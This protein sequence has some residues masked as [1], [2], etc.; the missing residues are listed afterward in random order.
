M[1]ARD[2]LVGG[3]IAAGVAKSTRPP[4]PGQCRCDCWSG[5]AG[6]IGRG[7]RRVV[8]GGAGLRRACDA[9]RLCW[10]SCRLGPDPG[11]DGGGSRGPPPRSK[12]SMTIMRP[13]QHGHGGR[14]SVGAVAVASVVASGAA[15]GLSA[16]SISLTRAMLAWRRGAG[17]EP[18][19]A[20]AVEALGQ[21]VKQEAPN[22]LARHEGHGPVSLPP[23]PAVVLVAE[24]D[25]VRVE[26]DQRGG[27][28]MA[29][30]W[31]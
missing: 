16:A 14:W 22:E 7:C 15:R 20:D 12:V 3:A 6:S 13:P 24:R 30:R 2:G 26:G 18:V 9:E 21:D 1:A 28:M 11:S 31:V 25:G 4:R 27:S 10:G 8:A 29:T 5:C 19:V 17:E 23:V